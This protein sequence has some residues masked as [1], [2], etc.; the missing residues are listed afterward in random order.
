MANASVK[1]RVLW[2][3]LAVL[4]L[5]A[6]MAV[7]SAVFPGILRVGNQAM[8]TAIATVI[9]AMLA[10]IAGLVISKRR[11]IGWWSLGFLALSLGSWIVF[12][13]ARPG[14]QQ[15]QIYLRVIGFFGVPAMVSLQLGVI[16]VPTIRATHWRVLRIIV[17]GCSVVAGL[18]FLLLV[19]GGDDGGWYG[20]EG[21]AFMGVL[22]LLA[23]F[24]T[25][26]V[27]VVSAIEK[28]TAADEHEIDIEHRTPVTVTCPRCQESTSIRSNTDS[29]CESCGMRIR[30][31]ITEPRC[32]C[33]YLLY[34]LPGEVCPECGKPI[35]SEHRWHMRDSA[36][37][38]SGQRP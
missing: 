29:A 1:T 18:L 11:R 37:Q 6:G 34:N 33:G 26:M 10:L 4:A 21:V 16:M 19:V 22:V 20:K 30:V 14:W 7:L 28:S 13:W 24:G 3:V 35:P 8:L 9:Y 5:A 32:D 38:S 27:P 12:I 15:E 25:V 31:N 17:G 36:A 23:L 2:A